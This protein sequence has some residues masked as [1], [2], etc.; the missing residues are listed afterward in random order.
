MLAPKNENRLP[1]SLVSGRPEQVPGVFEVCLCFEH[2]ST[3]D[4]VE[5]GPE[6][7]ALLIAS[8][9][10]PTSVVACHLFSSCIEADAEPGC[11]HP[12]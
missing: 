10:E 9:P 4:A 11:P 8:C 12:D 2:A 3:T 1:A 5:L 7:P 6:S